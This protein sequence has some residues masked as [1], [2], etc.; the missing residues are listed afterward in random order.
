MELEVKGDFFD[1]LYK[2]DKTYFLGKTIQG[3]GVLAVN[4]S[5]SRFV[6][7]NWKDQNTVAWKA[8]KRKSRGSL[9]IKTGRLKR[10]IRKLAVGRWYVIIGTD[11]PYAQIH[12]EGGTINERVKVKA[13]TRKRTTYAKRKRVKEGQSKYTKKKVGSQKIHVRSHYRQMNLTIEKRQ[14]MGNSKALNNR[15]ERYMLAQIKRE[16]R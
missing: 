1:K 7:K 8:R 13:H 14:F 10:S 6:H 9:M 5:K 2:L 4:F 15:I 12:N 16:L 11:V 3:I